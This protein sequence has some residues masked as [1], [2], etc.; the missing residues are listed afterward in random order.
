M[1]G[2]LIKAWARHKNMWR[3]DGSDDERPPDD[4]RGEPSSNETHD[5]R[6]DDEAPLCSKSNAAPAQPSYPG[7]VLSDKRDG[8]VVNVPASQANCVEERDVAAQTL[9][10]VASKT[11]R[12]T[13]VAYKAYDPRGFVK[14][15]RK[16][17]VTPL[18]AQNL[19]WLGGNAIDWR[20]TRHEGYAMRMPARKFLEQCFGWGKPVKPPAHAIVRGLDKVVQLLTV[21]AY[22]LTR[23]PALAELRPQ[24]AQ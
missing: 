15:C 5:S 13:V 11:Q 14:A 1:D 3:K 12:K 23:L 19:N 7:H 24:M 10:A 16:L 9:A 20:K 6:T 18:V 17:N 8:L 21:A 2:T 4:W 22:N